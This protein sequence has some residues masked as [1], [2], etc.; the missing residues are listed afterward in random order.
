MNCNTVFSRYLSMDV[1]IFWNDLMVY[2]RSLKFHTLKTAFVVDPIKG[3]AHTYSGD[4]ASPVG[5]RTCI[6]QAFWEF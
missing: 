1:N 4:I 2:D 6:K 3:T 5:I